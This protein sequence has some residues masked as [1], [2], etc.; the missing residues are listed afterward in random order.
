MSMAGSGLPSNIYHGFFTPSD[1]LNSFTIETGL[2]NLDGNESVVIGIITHDLSLGQSGY[3]NYAN[4]I[5][6]IGLINKLK[7]ITYVYTVKQ[8]GTGDY[9]GGGNIS[10]SNGTISITRLGSVRMVKDCKYEVVV[11]V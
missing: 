2:T 1:N 4:V 9:Y 5:Q 6:Y 8:D 10:I 7:T 11:M 3:P